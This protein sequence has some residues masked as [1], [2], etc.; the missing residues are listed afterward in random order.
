M[1]DQS[2]LYTGEHIEQAMHS[3]G[4]EQFQIEKVI[5]RLEA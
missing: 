2:V 1:S 5:E 4:I 3:V